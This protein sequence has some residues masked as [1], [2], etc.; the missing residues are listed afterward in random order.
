MERIHSRALGRWLALVLLLASTSAAAEC[1]TLGQLWEMY[2]QG[3]DSLVANGASSQLPP[4]WA[5][6]EGAAG[7]GLIA[8]NDG[9]AT[10]PGAYS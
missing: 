6:S 1:I 7:D 10:T 5:I 2:S 4:G 9:S 8:A 3:F